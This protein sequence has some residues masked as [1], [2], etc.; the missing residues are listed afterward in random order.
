[1]FF[2]KVKIV[3]EDLM[4]GYKYVNVNN[5]YSYYYVI[6]YFWVLLLLLIDFYLVFEWFYLLVG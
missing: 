6:F 4:G 5:R 3:E 2:K 1:M